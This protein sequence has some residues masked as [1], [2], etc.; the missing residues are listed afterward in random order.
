MFDKKRIESRPN[1]PQEDNEKAESDP[2]QEKDSAK[3]VGDLRVC[4]TETMTSAVA[5]RVCASLS[6]LLATGPLML[7]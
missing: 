2:E 7:S 3:G 6:I 5:S 1:S 4:A